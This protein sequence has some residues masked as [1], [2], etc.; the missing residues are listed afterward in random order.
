MIKTRPLVALGFLVFLSG[1]LYISYS[2]PKDAKVLPLLF[3]IPGVLLAGWNLLLESII[4]G[5]ET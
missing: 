3:L 1:A 5:C 4:D 2:F